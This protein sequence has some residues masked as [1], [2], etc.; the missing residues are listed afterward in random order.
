MSVSL[1]INKVN[2]PVA[3]LLAIEHLDGSVTANVEQGKATSLK[4]SDD[5]TFTTP[6][7]ICRYLARLAPSSGLYGNN[8]LEATEI[9]HWLEYSV[10]RL[11]NPTEFKDAVSD[12]DHILGPRTYL[13]AHGLTIADFAVWGALRAN[14]SWSSKNDSHVNLS[15]WYNFLDSQEKF[16]KVSC[17]LPKKE[18]KQGSTKTSDVGTFIELPGAK[19]GEVVVRFPPEASGYLHIGHAKAALLNQYYQQAF[20]GKLI[21]R[22]DDTNPAKES[23]EFEQVILE[24]LKLLDIQPDL[25]THTSDHFDRM[26]TI[27]EDLIKS[28]KAYVDDT[29]PEE[30]KRQRDLREES[31]NR[32]NSVEKNL[33]LWSEMKKGSEVGQKCALRMKM[34]MKSNNGCMRD[35]TIYRCKLEAHV[36]CGDKYKAYPT[37]DFACPIVDS[38]EGVTH[39]LRTTE[40]HDRDDQYYFILDAL[41]MRKPHI[42]EYSRLNLQHTV[43]SK[44]KLTWF[45]DE[46]LVEGWNDPR[47]PT[48]RGVI[49]RGMTIEGL[50]QFIAAQGSSRAVVMM[51]WD[52]IWS[53][54]RKVIDPIIPRYNGV[55]DK[56]AVPVTV[57][58]VKVEA[59]DVPKH[60]KNNAIGNKK[61]WY[62]D[63]VFVDQ[64]DAV[65]FNEGEIVTFINWGNLIIQKIN[66]DGSGKVISMTADLNLENEDY[67]KTTKITWLAETG[68]APFVPTTLIYFDDLISKGILGK[69][70]DFK[71]FVNKNSRHET[72]VLGD[73]ELASLK[74]GEIIQMQRKGYFICDQAYAPASRHTSRTSP[75]I[76]F[77]IPDGKKTTST[78]SDSTKNAPQEASKSKKG[79]NKGGSSDSAVPTT[80]ASPQEVEAVIARITAQGDS[81]RDLKSKKAAK[82]EIDQA[83]KV[84]LSLKS[85]YK[86]MTGVDYKPGAKPP[87]TDNPGHG[88]PGSD[89]P[90][91]GNPGH[92]NPGHGEADVAALVEK[93]TAQGDKVRSLKSSKAPKVDIDAE[94][95]ILLSL[96]VK[97]KAAT[98]VDYKP[99]SNPPKKASNP[100]HGNPGHG[101]PGSDNP[102]HGNAAADA[103]A[104]KIKEQGDK[105]RNLKSKKAPK[106]EVDAEVKTLLDLKSQYKTSTGSDYQPPGAK[107][108]EKK[109]KDKKGKGGEKESKQKKEAAAEEDSGGKK[110][111]RLGLEAKKEENLSDWYSQV[112][113]KSEMIEYYDVS[114]CYVLRP[115]SFSI[116]E[117]ITAFFDAEIKKLGVENCY[118][119]MFVSASALEREK[120]H[121]ADFAPEVAWVTRSGNSELAE[122][123][124]IRPTSETVMYPV[125]SKWVQSHRDLP[126]KLNQWCNVVRWEFKHPQPFLRTREF[127]WQEGHTAWATR[128]EAVDEVYKILELYAA[129]YEKLLAMPVVRGRKTEKEKFAGGDFTTTVEAFIVASGRGLQGAT[130]HHLG[131]NFSK[132]FD[133]SF[134]DPNEPNKREFAHQNS[135]GLSTRTIGAL[136][137]AHGDNVG[138]ILPPKVACVQVIIVPCG[139]TVKSTDEDKKA[140]N[141]KA[142]SYIALF[143]AADIRVKCD[144]RE[145]YSP[146][147]K[148]NHWELKGVP[149]RMEIGPRDISKNQ[150]VAVRRDTSEKLIFKEAEAVEKIGNLLEDIQSSLYN[151]ASKELQEHK[152]LSHDWD[153]FCTLLDQKNIIQIPFCGDIKCEETI[154]KDSARGQDAEPGAPSMGAKSLCIPMKQ[155]QELPEGTKCLHPECSNKAKYY[156]LFGRSY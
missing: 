112:I 25:F 8:I 141:D 148:F 121:I 46:K 35:P 97:Y 19:M 151:K 13:V 86:N 119:P 32:N 115:W 87:K 54:N 126:I 111:T 16:Q 43:L 109:G 39:A 71:Q 105:V 139:I 36:R 142:D 37:Y 125:Y 147:W 116:W 131:Q 38:L 93:I 42:W 84:L 12:L 5:L 83:V 152:K 47:F 49:R 106:E 51:E 118:F 92:G 21:M 91:H 80:T 67:R 24:D 28:S 58:G 90:G 133:I 31:K 145:N 15:R 78:T 102:G 108:Q 88:N 130:S 123:I 48:V 156:C 95:K 66:K 138:L 113:I 70:E 63:K 62:S 96:K 76:L 14:P 72:A 68:N 33:Q 73:P 20:K 110:Q 10:N 99:G 143:K 134:E 107:K 50:K 150:F 34:D 120:T 149:V 104:E 55:V 117:K 6:V 23:S 103:L 44:R 136:C 101:N 26:I 146:P 9:D 69:D 94:V 77:N 7:A 57:S 137:L 22:F 4:L 129:V 153:E 127:L 128:E 61:V 2:P 135:W 30:M 11:G 56:D 82:D 132:M 100:G 81:V 140:I 17:L 75:C 122:P 89:N 59:K 124:A 64:A 155:P 18:E 52:K 40:Y 79:K 29:D 154:K 45:V 85:D 65:L 114:G 41:K 74:K 27:A 3:A 144:D 53:F 1:T 98:G 60:A